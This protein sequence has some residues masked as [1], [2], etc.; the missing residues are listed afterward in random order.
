MDAL[1]KWWESSVKN[2]SVSKKEVSR[3]TLLKKY[4]VDFM[5]KEDYVQVANECA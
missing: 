5:E 4:W 2:P 3:E 1:S